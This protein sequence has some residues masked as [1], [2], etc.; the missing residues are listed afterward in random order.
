MYGICCR[1]QPIAFGGQ[2]HWWV[3]NIYITKN[4]SSISTLKPTWTTSSQS[5]YRNLNIYN[6]MTCFANCC[7]QGQDLTVLFSP[8]QC[9]S[10]SFSPLEQLVWAD[11][12]ADSP[13]EEEVSVQSQRNSGAVHLWC[14]GDL[15]SIWSNY[16]VCWWVGGGEMENDSRSHLN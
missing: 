2:I 11:L 6:S 13:L 14:D 9:D 8:V 15:T 16:K 10:T 5:V 3:H 1:L 7:F 4:E 12:N